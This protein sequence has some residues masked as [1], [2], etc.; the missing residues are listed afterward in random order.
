VAD[1]SL[2]WLDGYGLI[3]RPSLISSLDRHLEASV[4]RSAGHVSV[5][6]P[7]IARDICARFGE[8]LR[9]KISVIPTGFA[10]DL[11]HG[12]SAP[13]SAKFTIL[14][15]GNHLCEEGRHG[16]FFLQALDEWAGADPGV[17]DRV[18]FVAFGKRDDALLRRHASMSHPQM[19]RPEPLIPHRA[20]IE[21]TRSSDIC[22]V[23]AVGNRI[24]CKVYECMRAGK[25]VL[26]LTDP[27]SDLASLMHRYQRGMSV[28]ARDISG[29]RN[30][31]QNLY[32]AGRSDKS[33]P[34][35]TDPF[36][37]AHSSRRSAEKLSRIFENLL[38]AGAHQ[39]A[40]GAKSS[41]VAGFSNVSE[42]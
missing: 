11:F 30:A 39:R 18:E 24:P 17:R 21:A 32:Q 4:V 14:Y 40:T 6:Y 13:A 36:L 28:A 41:R 16:E 42:C 26:A 31:L 23:N 25:P 10:E 7:D 35:K 27:G 12:A 19:V 33:E 3:P 22:V 38:V 29:I 15:P 8:A 2:E 20:C 1:F 34:I 9:E 37:A 5:A